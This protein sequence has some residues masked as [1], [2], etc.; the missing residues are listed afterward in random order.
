MLVCLLMLCLVLDGFV[1]L[2]CVC[3]LSVCEGL[4]VCVGTG[5]AVVWFFGVCFEHVHASWWSLKRACVHFLCTQCSV[6]WWHLSAW[7]LCVIWQRQRG[8]SYVGLGVFLCVC[9]VVCGVVR[10]VLGGSRFVSMSPRRLASPP[11]LGT[12]RVGRW[13]KLPPGGLFQERGQV[14]AGLPPRISSER[15]VCRFRHSGPTAYRPLQFD[16]NSLRP[17]N[18]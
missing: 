12:P 11:T 10:L 7:C 6:V 14:D 5:T 15:F 9:A 1:G 8:H 18:Y 3:W 2:G 16:S 17:F 13:K 4:F